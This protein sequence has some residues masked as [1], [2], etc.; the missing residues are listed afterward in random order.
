MALRRPTVRSRSAPPKFHSNAFEIRP[1]ESLE[2]VL[3]VPGAALSVLSLESAVAAEAPQV[4]GPRPREH[5]PCARVAR[6]AHRPLDTQQ[7]TSSASPQRAHHPLEGGVL[8]DAVGPGRL[9]HPRRPL[10][11]DVASECLDE[12][13]LRQLGPLTR[14]L[15]RHRL[16]DGDLGR[17]ARR[18]LRRHVSPSPS[19]ATLIVLSIRRPYEAAISA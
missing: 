5:G 1:G 9:Q 4:T 8:D 15:I 12:L 2:P 11:L 19:D 3:K 13:N 10:G 16:V 18:R 6:S 14:L 17:S 7:E